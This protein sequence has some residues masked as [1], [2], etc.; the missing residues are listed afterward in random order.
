M[1]KFSSKIWATLDIHEQKYC[2]KSQNI[3]LAHGS[4]KAKTWPQ[5]D[6]NYLLLHD[7]FLLV[8]QDYSG[9]SWTI[10]DF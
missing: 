2:R 8:L 7:N 9:K 4:I 5:Y 6:P 1:H 10:F 3:V